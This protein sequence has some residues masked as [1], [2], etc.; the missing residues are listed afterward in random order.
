M[1]NEISSIGF[2]AL[3]QTSAGVFN[4]AKLNAS[5]INN[6]LSGVDSTN[7]DDEVMSNVST[8]KTS[9]FNFSSFLS[10]DRLQRYNGTNFRAYILGTLISVAE[11]SLPSGD[12]NASTK[13]I[14]LPS[15]AP[16]QNSE[17]FLNASNVLRPNSIIL[18]A[19]AVGTGGDL[20]SATEVTLKSEHIEEIDLIKGTIKL[21]E[22]YDY[23]D[24]KISF[25]K[26]P[27]VE[28]SNTEGGNITI[29][30]PLH[31]TNTNDQLS[32]NSNLTG[33]VPSGR[34]EV[35]LSLN[36]KMDRTKE[37]E[38]I[39][40]VFN[41]DVQ[42]QTPT[43]IV[44]KSSS[45][46]EF[47]EEFHIYGLFR[48]S[49][50]SI[51][52]SKDSLIDEQISFDIQSSG[53]YKHFDIAYNLVNLANTA[54]YRSITSNDSLPVRIK[55][56]DT[57]DGGSQGDFRSTE[58]LLENLT[59]NLENTDLINVDGSGKIIREFSNV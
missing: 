22:V 8:V 34:L 14:T 59:I 25:V 50:G 58:I 23:S 2:E 43:L 7:L 57:P 1:A 53:Y 38:A 33:Y 56:L 18:K 37:S 13:T 26:A 51:T 30:R 47:K 39:Q 52:F 35:S 44:W 19:K 16:A 6:N 3:I 28:L 55:I 46:T 21:S 40:R 10:N 45:V 9:T 20:A 27:L 5:D 17:E 11:Y 41:Q 24:F 32:Q 54:L 48:P 36:F 12:Y 29:N 15:T 31:E 4:L 49:D 42:N